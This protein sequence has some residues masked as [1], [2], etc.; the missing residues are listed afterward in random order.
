MG[1]ENRPRPRRV[2]HVPRV[3]TSHRSWGLSRLSRQRRG[4]LEF[5]NHPTA[6]R[7]VH[8]LMANTEALGDVSPLGPKPGQGSGPHHRGQDTHGSCCPC[9]SLSLR[10]PCPSTASVNGPSLPTAPE[11]GADAVLPGFPANLAMACV[12]SGVT[13]KT[14]RAPEQVED[15]S[16]RPHHLADTRGPL[17]SWDASAPAWPSSTAL[18]RPTTGPT[19][20][21]EPVRVT[22][23]GRKGLCMND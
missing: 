9:V 19:E 6:V 5:N 8:G 20:R 10:P 17:L 3:R 18:C 23:C 13:V 14:S 11:P 22:F 21:L 2:T 16:I 7:G 15:L 1:T 4:Q 12:H